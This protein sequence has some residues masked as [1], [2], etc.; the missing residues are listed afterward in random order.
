MTVA[1]FLALL[2]VGLAVGFV[3]GLVGIGGGVLI[4]PV[5]YFVYAA[6]HWSGL[7]VAPELQAA[8][9]HATSLFIIV[10][11]AIRGVISYQRS[12]LIAWRAALP[13]A[14]ASLV[15]AVVG[16]RLA[17]I[18][19]AAG[20]KIGFGALLLGT[21]AQL[22]WG[23]VPVPR[24]ARARQLPIM[25]GIGLAAGVLSAML[26]VGGGIIVIP[27]L[28]L[29]L[30]LPMG[31]VAATSMAVIVFAAS[32]G[33]VAY[34]VS[35]WGSPGLPPGNVGYVHLAVAI[36][37]TIGSV[38]AVPWGAEVNQRLGSNRLRR[39]FG[40]FFLILGAQLV[41]RNLLVF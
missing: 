29:L 33:A 32:A 35:G 27:L 38:L 5:L 34:M 20:L 17:L 2:G 40:I 4:V 1:V 36:P 15:A 41:L 22:L 8:V 28:I 12:G 23:R 18:V 6:P 14:G 31:R 7:E 21:A 19:P 16:A 3:S 26:G 13:I 37:M 25:L 10:P 24:A 9:A 11:T 39:I 30:G